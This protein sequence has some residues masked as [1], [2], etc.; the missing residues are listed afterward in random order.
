M[1]LLNKQNVK[2]LAKESAKKYHNK[3]KVQISADFL[4]QIEK[5]VEAV[6]VTNAI[7]QDDLAGTLRQTKWGRVRLALAKELMD[8]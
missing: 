5:L 8:A 3:E 1:S 2:A 7:R 6:V 4:E